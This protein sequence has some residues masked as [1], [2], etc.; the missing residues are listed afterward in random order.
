[1]VGPALPILTRLRPRTAA[2]ATSQTSLSAFLPSCAAVAARCPPAHARA[3]HYDLDGKTISTIE[4]KGEIANVLQD[5]FK[6]QGLTSTQADAVVGALSK[7]MEGLGQ[8]GQRLYNEGVEKAEQEFRREWGQDYEARKTAVHKTILRLGGQDLVDSLN[9]TGY[10]NDPL[11][12]RFVDNMNKLVGD[13]KMIEGEDQGDT[14]RRPARGI[15]YK[16][17]E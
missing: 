5:T 12:I 2:G 4:V 13:H 11:L 1:M 14:G 10:G 17:E 16:D 6:N 15:V 8:T 7:V 3:L 9:K